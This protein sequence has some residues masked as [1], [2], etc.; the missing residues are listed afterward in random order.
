MSSS[1]RIDADILMFHLANEK[2]YVWKYLFFNNYVRSRIELPKYL[3]RLRPGINKEENKLRMTGRFLPASEARVITNNLFSK[4]NM[5]SIGQVC[6]FV[7][8]LFRILAHLRTMAEQANID[9][10]SIEDLAFVGAMYVKFLEV[11]DF[12]CDQSVTPGR[13]TDN[14]MARFSADNPQLPKSPPPQK[15]F[16]IQDRLC[17]ISR[18][19]A[20]ETQNPCQMMQK[21]LRGYL[22]RLRT[23]YKDE[24]PFIVQGLPVEMCTAQQCCEIPFEEGH[25]KKTQL[26]E[27]FRNTAGFSILQPDIGLADLQQRQTLYRSEEHQALIKK[28]RSDFFKVMQFSGYYN[29]IRGQKRISMPLTDRGWDHPF[30]SYENHYMVCNY[31]TRILADILAV[32]DRLSKG[33][34]AGRGTHSGYSVQ[35]RAPSKIPQQ[36]LVRT[37]MPDPRGT[38]RSGTDRP[39]DIPAV[40]PLDTHS[41]SRSA[42]LLVAAAVIAGVMLVR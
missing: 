23:K 31:N 26:M 20:L 5:A 36:A 19:N 38:A 35:V 14:V 28:I 17:R 12:M 8:N 22:T 4:W 41:F 40:P 27:S 9:K 25:I 42:I 11:A 34:P 13:R 6:Q 16:A 33:Q 32:A 7:R 3:A 1:W 2:P 37:Q 21:L 29:L 39:Q 18:G 30:W 15:L 24:V 10:S